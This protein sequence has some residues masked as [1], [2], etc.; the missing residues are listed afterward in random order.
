MRPRLTI[1][2]YTLLVA[3]TAGAAY[4]AA[5]DPAAIQVQALGSSLLEAMKAGTSVSTAQ[6]YRRLEPV[7]EQVFALPL[8]TRLSVGP[9]WTSFQPQQQSALVA[10]FSRYTIANYAHNF[11]DY[12]GQKFDVDENVVDR[13]EE[14][15]VRSRL[16]SPND[17]PVN[18][19]YRMR[20]VNGVWKIV[21]VYFNGVSQ[22]ILHRTEF[23]EAIASGGPPALI[24]HLNEVSDGLMK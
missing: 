16:E 12:K 5:G 1:L 17:T 10:A 7:I 24:A 3:P 11:H 14:K 15:I 23:S 21:D 18:F 8:M 20:E 22:L 13:G 6:R 19:L 2:L 9:S 4:A